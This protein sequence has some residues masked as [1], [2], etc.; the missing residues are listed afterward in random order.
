MAQIAEHAVLLEIPGV[1]RFYVHAGKQVRVQADSDVKAEDLR[2][3]L[4][5]SAFGAIYFQRGFFPLHASVV[6]INGGPSRA[7]RVPANRPSP[8]G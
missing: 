8:R 2:L 1:G 5:G 4:L 7:I 3:F 6:V